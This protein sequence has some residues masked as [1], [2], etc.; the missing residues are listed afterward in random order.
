MSTQDTMQTPTEE[1]TVHEWKPP[2]AP[3]GI[4]LIS[5]GYAEHAGRYE[6]LAQWLT[7]AGIM[8]VAPDYRG[9]GRSPG[10]R[11]LLQDLDACA[12]DLAVVRAT[13]AERHGKL[14]TALIGHSMG[15]NIAIRF[16]QLGYGDDL[17]AL[18]LSGPVAG[19]NPDVFALANHDP[20]VNVPLDPAVLSRDHNVG[21]A[22]NADPLV[23]HG[24][25]LRETLI[26][27]KISV[28]RI[29]A[30]PQLPTV[31]TLWVHGELD[32]LA[33]LDLTRD[34]LERIRGRR[35]DGIVYPE[36]R[37]EIFNETN[38]TDVLGDVVSFVARCVKK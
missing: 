35:F 7:D 4:V 24:P 22:F 14:P 10:E 20:I 28:D 17:R 15:G 6:R 13:A 2:H 26:A 29:A 25:Y 5:H 27:Y 3:A 9:H 36:A 12:N 31:P 30:G 16:M 37:H 21:K 19:G 1:L 32:S 11:G 38:A 18:V 23:Y 33:P 34:A 8:V